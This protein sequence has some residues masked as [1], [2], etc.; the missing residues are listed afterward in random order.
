MKTLTLATIASLTLLSVNA[1]SAA[2]VTY[3]CVGHNKAAN[4]AVVFEL[5]FSDHA[6]EVG[7]TNQ[8]ITIQKRG[9]EQLT[10]PITLQMFGA[11][12]KNN[13]KLNENNEYNLHAS[14]FKMDPAP[15]DLP[16]YEVSFKSACEND[17]QFDV[18]GVCFFQ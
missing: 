5:M 12:K 14:N 11:T 18:R 9:Y 15:G 6:R 13:C 8:S 3:T 10:N 2:A 16:A 1:F 17:Q 4:E 7:Y